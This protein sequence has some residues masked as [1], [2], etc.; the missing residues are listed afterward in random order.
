M[1]SAGINVGVSLNKPVQLQTSKIQEVKEEAYRPRSGL[2]CVS[3][4]SDDVHH[5]THNDAQQHECTTSQVS[6]M[7]ANP[8]KTTEV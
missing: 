2:M 7:A 4:R 6:D 1:N 3:V 8:L 5:Q